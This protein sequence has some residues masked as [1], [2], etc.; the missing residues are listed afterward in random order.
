VVPCQVSSLSG[1]RTEPD[2][3][4]GDRPHDALRFGT[5][6]ALWGGW[7]IDAPGRNH[8]V[9]WDTP[10]ERPLHRPLLHP[11]TTTFTMSIPYIPPEILVQIADNISDEH[12]NI[13][14]HDFNSFLQVNQT[15]YKYLNAR[16]WKEAANHPV[17]TQRVF[18]HLIKTN[19]LK[20]LGF[21]L[22]LGGDP[23]VRLTAFRDPDFEEDP[24]EVDG[25]RFHLTPT[26]LLI[27]VELDNGPLMRVLLE[28]GAKIEYSGPSGGLYSPLH[29]ARSVET[30]QL[31][32]SYNA[33]PDLTDSGWSPLHWYAYRGH[34]A[35]MRAI[36]QHG[37]QVNAVGAATPVVPLH[38]AVRYCPRAGVELLVT[39]GADVKALFY[40]G[41]TSFSL[42]AG[43]GN[44]EVVKYLVEQWPEGIRTADNYLRT[45]L[46]M[47]AL[48][49]KIEMVRFLVESCPDGV[50][51][52]NIDLDTPLHWAAMGDG[53][54]D[55]VKFL[56]DQWPAGM[57]ERN[58]EMK[59]PLHLAA[60]AGK[61]DVVKFLVEQWPEGIREGDN[62]LK[63]PLDL[64]VIAGKTDVVKLLVE[65]WHEG[66]EARNVNAQSLLSMVE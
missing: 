22:D 6:S 33:N 19:N 13:R 60:M 44:I 38:H 65:R 8:Q 63:T 3:P 28:K 1:H 34:I 12:G 59:T 7:T 49:G 32:L 11:N 30:V 50:R 10:S 46:H 27:A 54:T 36:L 53:K 15:L 31:L 26:P 25:T 41:M 23:E 64:A 39:Y 58:N 21:F 37:A 51:D 29:A 61:T 40:N 47:A 4:E 42:A 35:A 62:G 16:L 17:D 24:E 66:R 43:E 55:V 2:G 5:P 48:M 18:T 20:A 14:Y 57:R 56:V 45:P 9:I 52:R